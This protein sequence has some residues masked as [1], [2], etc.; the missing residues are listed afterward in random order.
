M[1]KYKKRKKNDAA[2][3]YY[4]SFENRIEIYDD[5][6]PGT[7]EFGEIIIFAACDT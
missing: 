4:Y 1:E 3:Y 5:V 7:Y 2:N 6:P